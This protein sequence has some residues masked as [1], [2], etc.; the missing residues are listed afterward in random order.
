MMQLEPDGSNPNEPF[1]EVDAN[2]NDIEMHPVEFYCGDWQTLPAAIA[3]KDAHTSPRYD[4]ILTSETL[5]NPNAYAKLLHVFESTL[6]F[7]DG[8]ALVASKRYYFGCG[9]STPDFIQFVHGHAQTRVV[10]E[11][12]NSYRLCV[13]IVAELDQKGSHHG[14]AVPREILQVSWTKS[15]AE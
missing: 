5:Y 14:S 15:T 8:V 6:S 12:D 9:G 11:N 2:L 10:P 13:D 4:L 3:A 7:P 1:I